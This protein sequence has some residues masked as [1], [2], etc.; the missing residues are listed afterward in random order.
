MPPRRPRSR[1]QGDIQVAS[2]ETIPHIERIGKGD[3]QDEFVFVFIHPQIP[4]G[5]IEIRVMPQD[6]AGYPAENYFLVYTNDEAPPKVGKILDEAMVSTTGMPIIELLRA[7]SRRLCD[8]LDPP[9]KDED[10][11]DDNYT[12]MA[13]VDED[14]DS[15]EVSYDSDTDLPFDYGDGGHYSLISGRRDAPRISLPDTT[16]W[17][18]RRDF[19]TVR[20][21]GFRVGKIY[22]VDHESEYSIVAMS[23]RASKLCL[24]KETH[25]AWNLEPSDYVVLLMKYSGEYESFEH[26]VGRPA[27][28]TPLEF[29]LR[30]CSRYRPTLKAAMAAFSSLS[31]EQ[32]EC[33]ESVPKPAESENIPKAAGELWTFSVGGSIDL[34]LN[35]DFLTMM[36]LRRMEHVSW[37]DAK[38]IQSDLKVAGFDNES[39]KVPTLSSEP[40]NTVD[41]NLPPILMDDHLTS[42]HPISLPLIAMQFSLRYLVKCTDYCMICHERITANF[43]A[44][45]PYVCANPLCLFQYMSLG[46]GPSID[47]EIVNHEYVVDLLI[48]FCYASLGG[49]APKLRE[50]PLGLNLEVPRVRGLLLYKAAPQDYIVGGYGS[51][52]DPLEV[53]V[54][55]PDNMAVI[56]S[57]FGIEHP[58]LTI[59]KWVVIHT[60]HNQDQNAPAQ[61]ATNKP[62]KDIFHYACIKMKSGPTLHLQI[63]SRFPVPMT[64]NGFDSVSL[65]PW[66]KMKPTTGRLVLCNLSL[67]DLENDAEKAFSLIL[68][69]SVLPSVG[70]MREYLMG[71]RSRQLATWNRIPPAAM[72]LLRWIIASNRS[73]IVHLNNPH[74]EDAD[75]NGTE[76]ENSDR[77]Q[78][79]I[80]GLDGWVQFRFA[81]GSPEK[82]ALFLDALQEVDHPNRT[83]LAWHGSPLGNWHSIIREGLNYKVTAHG[84]AYGHGVYFSRSFEYSL[85]YSG[86]NSLYHQLERAIWPQ[87][88][89]QITGA[90]S[91]NELV[92]LPQKFKHH[93]QC[94]VVDILHW[95][96]CRYLFVRPKEPAIA[97]PEGKQ[98]RRSRGKEFE[99]DPRHAITGPSNS[100]IFVPEIAIPSVQQRQRRDFPS[101]KAEES[102][103]DDT[104]DED[105]ED[106]DFLAFDDNVEPQIAKTEPRMSR[107]FPPTPTCQEFQTDFRPGSLDF[108]KLPQLAIP[109][110]ATRPAQQTIQKELLKLQKVQSATP[111]HE[112]GW[113]IDF[114]RIENMFQWIVELHSFDASL[115][116]TQDMKAAGIT[117]IVVEVRFLRGFPM[118]PPFVRVIKPRFLPFS[119]GGGGHVTAGGAMCMELL[120]NTG[121]SPVSSMESVLLQVRLAMSNLEPKPA[122]LEKAGSGANEYSIREAV[123]A[124]IRAANSHGWEVPAEVKEAT[125]Q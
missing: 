86:V 33:G 8:S 4:R 91:L 19:R 49:G 55:W 48:S 121:W 92:N 125:Q 45:K 17:R 76:G 82:E 40:T 112:L 51:L 71:D 102:R 78:E 73:F 122:R 89:L 41:A 110:Y 107:N 87:S 56:K 118:T 88:S 50:F 47:D 114:E 68:L 104:D 101:R 46:L 117:S 72:K 115:P 108:S 62:V 28:Q 21:A 35:S 11:G 12:A 24:S 74:G 22:G 5:E 75:S 106:I 1:L 54:N 27:G 120:T 43:D 23:V 100:K 97:G 94:Y 16:L 9:V 63:A 10:S 39:M 53:E 57:K 59:G 113:Y 42:Q 60:C 15:S 14:T 67:D 119:L 20:N 32:H 38:K 69:F 105:I 61:S 65:L 6:A 83:I 58:D 13:D 95:I 2:H 37:D 66:D 103:D 30:K 124:Y 36:K 31:V 64:L 116:L 111:L 44:L 109:S 3:V 77:S 84:R 29:R 7:L 52:M 34:L 93:H 96:Q 80:S 85:G 18:I 123:D 90:I 70:E 25:T 81:Q 99:Q 26:A 98:P 79:R